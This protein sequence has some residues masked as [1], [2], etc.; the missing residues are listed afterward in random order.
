LI[1]LPGKDITADDVE[2]YV[3]PKNGEI[4]NFLEVYTTYENTS[5]RI[6]GFGT[7]EAVSRAGFW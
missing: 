7:D 5:I 1:I 2:N 6:S 4:R 3:L